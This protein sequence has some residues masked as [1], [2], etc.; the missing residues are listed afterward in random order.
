LAGLA[1]TGG[2]TAILSSV[3]AGRTAANHR[4]LVV[5]SL[6]IDAA[7]GSRLD[8]SDNDLVL[9]GGGAAGL[10]LVQS[11][12]RSGYARGTWAG[13]GLASSAAAAS[14]LRFN[15]GYAVNDGAA[16]AQRSAFG[17]GDAEPVGP[18]DVLAKY[19]YSGD[20]NLDG[21]V[22]LADYA[23]LDPNFPRNSGSQWVTGDLNHDG[24][25]SLADY[26]L[27]DP[28]FPQPNRV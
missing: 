6:S 26:T 9:R 21:R 5:N 10:S 22:S 12:V 4:I 18:A 16:A 14:N 3:G 28:L 7:S 11:L 17:P 25:T 15:L 27:I 8:L 1:L 24:R 13:G 2:A 20:A 23:L 19:T